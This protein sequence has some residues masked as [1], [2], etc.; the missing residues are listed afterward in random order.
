M[1]ATDDDLFGLGLVGRQTMYP[2]TIGDVVENGLGKGI[3]LLED[4]ADLGPELHGIHAR[5]I[6]ILAI[7]RDAASHAAD[8]DYVVHAV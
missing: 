3:G 8:F 7:Q 4:H 5:R 2:G 1:Q 6:D